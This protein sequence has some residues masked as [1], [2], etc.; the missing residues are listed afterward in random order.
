MTLPLEILRQLALR[1]DYPQ[2]ESTLRANVRI[3]MDAGQRPTDEQFR[4]ALDQLR[5]D[6]ALVT[7]TNADVGDKHRITDTGL[8]RLANAGH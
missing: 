3:A 1:P 8:A 6:H 7:V 2:L 5:A 4:A